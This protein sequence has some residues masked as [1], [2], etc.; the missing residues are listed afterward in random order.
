MK[1]K[2]AF[3]SAKV[4]KTPKSSIQKE[5]IENNNSNKK[6][7]YNNLSLNINNSNKERKIGLLSS[8]K[9][10]YNNTSSKCI[11]SFSTTNNISSSLSKKKKFSYLSTRNIFSNIYNGPTKSSYFP[12]VLTHRGLI[13]SPSAVNSHIYSSRFFKIEDEK[14]AQQIYYLKNNINKMNKNLFLLGNENIEKDK[15]LTEKENEINYIINK[16]NRISHDNINEM[17]SRDKKTYLNNKEENNEEIFDYYMNNLNL[18]IIFNDITLNNYNYNNL[19]TRIRVQIIKNLK[20]IEEKEEKIIK[21]K[22]SIFYTKMNEIDIT[23][24]LYKQQINKINILINNAVSIYERNKIKIKE[25]EALEKKI[26]SQKKVLNCLNKEF[27]NIKKEE[28][29]LN[30]QIKKMK[31][32][33]FLKNN[34]KFKNLNLINDLNKKSDALSKDKIIL[35]QFDNKK[36]VQKIKDLKKNVELF[37]FHFK[38]TSNE[39]NKLKKNRENILSNKK[40]KINPNIYS[41]EKNISIKHQIFN[42]PKKIDLDKKIEELSL[43][44]DKKKY[45]ENWLKEEYEKYENKF[46]QMMNNDNNEEE[47]NKNDNTDNNF[48]DIDNNNNFTKKEDIN[49]ESNNYNRDNKEDLDKT[50]KNEINED[51]PYFS[52]EESNIPEKTNKFNKLQFKTFE[53]ILFKNFESKNILL[54]ESQNKIIEP[55]INIISQ[56]NIKEIKYNS[57]SFNIIINE[58]TKII[59]SALKNINQKNQKL[60]S[61]FIGTI[62]HISNYNINKLIEYI[63]LLFSYTTNYS[64]DEEKYIYKLQTKYKDQLILLY[65]KLYEYINNNLYTLSSNYIPLLKMKEIIEENKIQ[66]KEK[67]TAFLYYYMKK[68]NDPNSNLDDLEFDILNNF[69]LDNTNSNENDSVTEITNEEYEKQLKEAIDIIKKGLNQLDLNFGNLIKDITYK[70]EIDGVFYDYFTIE[71]FNE[72]L[73]KNKIILSELKLSCLCNKYCLPE[74]L[75]FIDK[76]KI[77]NDILK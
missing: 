23:S 16:N 42:Y 66:L 47:E 30:E 72:E 5:F 15:I 40:L 70:A 21:N 6:K 11:R 68:F 51:N 64:L 36:M 75:K 37:K 22:K 2:R 35:L 76:N 60:I 24:F 45:Y 69:F 58:L 43:E 67:Y 71:N 46:N 26:K 73:K 7:K 32:V 29:L 13:K 56:N 61:I 38:H 34:K 41:K 20:E 52:S 74:N 54:N 57:D 10:N 18:N 19:F 49:I 4:R 9:K 25:Y 3:L 65:N 55:F 31:N 53:Y 12:T 8:K 14:L 27:A 44:Y 28:L 39:I 48:D 17:L 1:N 62:I 33:L 59:M 77:E 50:I 63:N